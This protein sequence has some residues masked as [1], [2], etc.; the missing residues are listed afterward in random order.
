MDGELLWSSNFSAPWRTQHPQ[1]LWGP[2]RRSPGPSGIYPDPPAYRGENQRGGAWP[3]DAWYLDDGTLCGS[4]CDLVKAL[5][6]IEEGG[7]ARGL[8]LNRSK[9]LLHIF[10]DA[11]LTNNLL[12]SDIPISRMGFR[13]LGSLSVPLSFAKTW[14]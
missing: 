1:L 12:P 2:A 6:I 4:A 3:Q 11:D 13:V 10:E 14:C 8:H 5:K 7:P 9:S